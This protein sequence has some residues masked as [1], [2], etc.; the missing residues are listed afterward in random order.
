MNDAIRNLSYEGRFVYQH[1]NALEAMQ[2]VHTLEDGQEKER[3]ISLNGSAR[4]VVRNKDK[5]MCIHTESK[6][7]DVSPRDETNRFSTLLPIKPDRLAEH[8]QFD[9]GDTE[10]VAG[11]IGQV[12]LIR[13]MDNMRY[14][15]RLVLDQ[16]YALPLDSAMMDGEGKL[17][18]RMM[19]TDLKI[20]EPPSISASSGMSGSSMQNAARMAG[21]DESTVSQWDFTR[22]P[23]GFAL[24]VHRKKMM[25]NQAK[26]DHFVFSDGLAS[27]SVYVEGANDGALDGVTS[28]GS[29][30]AMGKRIGSHQ[31]TVV[32]EVPHGALEI[33]IG[34]IKAKTQ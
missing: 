17:I 18:S 2:I 25:P 4:E 13:P 30:N 34:G 33:V 9:M 24:N 29:V 23:N 3:L 15:Y 11:R 20:G 12:V 21:K 14:G 7:V 6:R 16:H 32:G 10:R 5:V 1:H 27:I 19:F 8:Y 26:V 28:M 31:V 22:L